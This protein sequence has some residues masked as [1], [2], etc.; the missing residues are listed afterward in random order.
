MIADTLGRPLRD[1]RISITDRCNFRC[2]Y[3][4][5]KSVFDRDYEFLPRAELLT[6]EELERTAGIFAALGVTKLRITGGEPLLRRGMEDLVGR[7]AATGGVDDLALTTNGSLLR[8]KAAALAAAGLHRVTVSLDSVDPQHFAAMNDVDFELDRV[9]DGIA[10]ATEAG[11]GPVKINA[12]VQRGVNDGD[13]EA[14]A[15]HFRGSGHVV[16]FIEFMDVGTANGWRMND[17]VPAREIVARIGARWPLDPVDQDHRGE[18][19]TRYRYRDGAGEI[20]V[21]ASVTAPFCGDCTRL[22]LSADGKLYTCLFAHHG[23]DLR[24]RLRDGSN[25]EA[26]ASALAGLW[27]QRSDRYSEM[28]SE[29]TVNLPKV[30]MSYI[31]G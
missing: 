31:G 17:V 30:E 9:L 26:V 28:R 23:F 27:E 25:D 16:R 18:V 2:T 22:R 14:M 3:C 29:V 15:E 7:L 11:L 8:R 19:A 5:P 1:L 20:G 6:F 12:V 4:M 21:I 13:I 24:E 10:A